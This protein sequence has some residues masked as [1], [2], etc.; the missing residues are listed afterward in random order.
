VDSDGRAWSLCAVTFGGPNREGLV[1]GA[2]LL[3]GPG[4]Q[5]LRAALQV[6][7][8]RARGHLVQAAHVVVRNVSVVPLAEGAVCSCDIPCICHL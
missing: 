6:G 8:L 5:G 1:G 2:L 4:L 7:R 3:S